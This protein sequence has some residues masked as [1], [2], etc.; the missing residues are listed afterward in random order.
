MACSRENLTFTITFITGL[1][2]KPQGCA[3]AF[4]TKKKK[5]RVRQFSLCVTEHHVM[6]KYRERRYISTLHAVTSHKMA[7]SKEKQFSKFV[8]N[9][10]NER[11]YV[12]AALL[13]A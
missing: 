13:N 1:H 2:N 12:H 4:S 6:K 8:A 5:A 3:A 10:F 11:L 9:T 7:S